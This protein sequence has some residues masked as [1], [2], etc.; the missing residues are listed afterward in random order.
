MRVPSA[1]ALAVADAEAKASSLP[2]AKRPKAPPPSRKMTRNR[3][4]SPAPAKGSSSKQ[5][6]KGKSRSTRSGASIMSP[7][8]EAENEEG[9]D[10]DMPPADD[11]ESREPDL[12]LCTLRLPSPAV[13]GADRLS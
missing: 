6:G 9:A 12:T 5:K 4:V 7:G 1:R 8:K 2:K 10:E 3:K 13:R 11:S